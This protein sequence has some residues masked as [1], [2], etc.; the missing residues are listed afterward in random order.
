M[1]WS[2]AA[3]VPACFLIYVED[4]AVPCL[5]CKQPC[6]ASPVTSPRRSA[7]PT[8]ARSLETQAIKGYNESVLI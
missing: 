4:I 2:L 3:P 8:K 5:Q 6:R 1:G 7:K